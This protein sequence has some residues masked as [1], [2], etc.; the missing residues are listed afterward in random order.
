MDANENGDVE[1]PICLEERLSSAWKHHS[2]H[3]SRHQPVHLKES[4][5]N[6]SGETIEAYLSQVK[7]DATFIQAYALE[8]SKRRKRPVFILCNARSGS[9][10]EPA[11]TNSLEAMLDKEVRAEFAHSI[12]GNLK[13][14]QEGR[15]R[16]AMFK[17]AHCWIAEGKIPAFVYATR[18]IKISSYNR[19]HPDDPVV[20]LPGEVESL[21]RSGCCD[22][23]FVDY[24]TS[25]YPGSFTAKTGGPMFPGFKEYLEKAGKNRYTALLT[26]R[27]PNGN[28]Y[29]EV[30]Q[31]PET[32][33]NQTTQVKGPLAILLNALPGGRGSLYDFVDNSPVLLGEFGY[34]M[35]GDHASGEFRPKPI[36]TTMGKVEAGDFVRMFLKSR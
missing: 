18:E 9:H 34:R 13:G 12:R 3:P 35:A 29:D 15:W 23:I 26:T 7:E 2:R 10:L 27:N 5:G 36:E 14:R 21:L 8:L 32:A 20:A 25:G 30:R 24:S 19:D 33:L 17:A 28:C 6:R 11:I 4:I 16:A 22:I 31:D 1:N